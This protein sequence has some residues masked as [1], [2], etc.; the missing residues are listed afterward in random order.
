MAKKKDIRLNK[1]E[2][3]AELTKAN[4][5]DYVE[6][7][8]TIEQTE[9][10][11]EAIKKCKVIRMNNLNGKETEITDIQKLRAEF[12]RIFPEFEY[13]NKKKDKEDKKPK[14]SDEDKLLKILAKKKAK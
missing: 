3:K 10:Y 13:L 11:I 6:R 8:A 9:A 12:I 1:P 2:S 7:Y 4:M 5:M 14:E